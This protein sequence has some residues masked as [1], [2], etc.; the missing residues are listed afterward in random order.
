[1]SKELAIEMFFFIV[2]I[3]IYFSLMSTLKKINKNMEYHVDFNDSLR[4]KNAEE[5]STKKLKVKI[6]DDEAIWGRENE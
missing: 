2:I 3:F 6:N 5:P 4:G 1:M